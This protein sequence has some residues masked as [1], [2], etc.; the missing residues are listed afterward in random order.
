[1]PH[2][3]CNTAGIDRTARRF[4]ANSILAWEVHES[5]CG[6]CRTTWNARGVEC[7]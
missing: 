5:F 6:Q 2:G 3:S 7:E 4:G 1:M